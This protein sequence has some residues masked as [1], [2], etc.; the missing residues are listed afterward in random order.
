M[1]DLDRGGDLGGIGRLEQDRRL[2]LKTAAPVGDVRLQLI[3]VLA[4]ALG[5]QLGLEAL[6]H[7][8]GQGL[9]AGQCLGVGHGPVL[10]MNRL[11]ARR[12]VAVG[13]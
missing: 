13:H 7:I 6:D 11:A 8:A 2:A 4:P 1:A 5:A 12:R 10:V 9:R 3:R